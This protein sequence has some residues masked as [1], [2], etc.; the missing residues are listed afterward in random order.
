MAEARAA[1]DEPVCAIRDISRRPVSDAVAGGG[2]RGQ[3]DMA[4]LLAAE[5][6]LTGPQLFEHIA[7]ADA[8][9]AHGH[10]CRAHRQV[11][12]QIAHHGCHQGV[13]GQFAGLLHRQRQD[14]HDRVTVDDL[15]GGIDRQ[16]PVGVAVVRQTQVGTVGDHRRSHRI[17][18]CRP[19]AVVDVETVGFGVDGDD[20]GAG[21]AVG[22]RCGRRRGAVRAVDDDGQPVERATV[23]AL[24]TWRR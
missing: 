20:V 19:A 9:G 11:Q 23:P 13:V 1:S 21:R 15:A 16:A 5:A 3:H 14:H 2:Q 17:Q 22:P 8:G 10:P 24:P 12:A 7:V 6:V 18:V 4:G